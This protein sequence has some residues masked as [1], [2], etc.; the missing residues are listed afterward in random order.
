MHCGVVCGGRGESG[1]NGTRWALGQLSVT[2][3][4]THKQIGP[5]WCWFPGGWVCVHSRTLWVSPTNYP[6]QLGVSPAM[7]A[8]IGFYSQRF[9]VFISP[10]WNPRF[11]SLSRSPVVPSGLS[12]C[13]CGITLST[14]HCLALPVL[15]TPPCYTFSLPQLPVST[16]ATGLNEC[17]FFN[18]LVVRLPYSLIFWKFCLSFIF[19]FVVSFSCARRQSVLGQKSPKILRFLKCI[20]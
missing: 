1:N 14:S 3:P 15:Q 2:F 12:A 4:D 9:W 18:S 13:K 16:P 5:V 8:P 10:R 19:K 11:C 6:V 17:F 7:V 20:F